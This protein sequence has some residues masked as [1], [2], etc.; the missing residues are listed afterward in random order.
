MCNRKLNK[1]PCPEDV[2]NLFTTVKDY[3][4]DQMK[5]DK[6][7]GRFTTT[8]PEWIKFFFGKPSEAQI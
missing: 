7:A 8:K 4:G 5:E 6:C 2:N 3:Q 1:Y